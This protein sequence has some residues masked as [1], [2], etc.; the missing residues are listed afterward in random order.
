MLS[1]LKRTFKRWNAYMFCVAWCAHGCAWHGVGPVPEMPPFTPEQNKRISYTPRWV[2]PAF[3]ISLFAVYLAGAWYTIRNGLQLWDVMMPELWFYRDMP[4]IPFDELARDLQPLFLLWF[5][6]LFFAE[7][8]HRGKSVHPK[9]LRAISFC[10]DFL[11]HRI[12]A[13][14]QW[15]V[16]MAARGIA[17]S[18]GLSL[19]RVGANCHARP[20]GFVDF[21][22]AE[23]RSRRKKFCSGHHPSENS[24]VKANF[25]YRRWVIQSIVL[26]EKPSADYHELMFP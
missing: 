24:W 25:S 18:A 12:S 1:V 11:R 19:C 26:F 2:V 23:G 20:I 16:V 8:Y 9:V 3:A 10:F 13:F 5:V 6:C 4:R 21:I 7:W 15:R 14:R 17:H 22:T